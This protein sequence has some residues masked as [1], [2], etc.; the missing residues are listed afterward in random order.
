MARGQ[1]EDV[2]ACLH[3]LLRALVTVFSQAE[4]AEVQH[5]IGVGE[6]GLALDTVVDIILEEDKPVTAEALLAIERAAEL[7]GLSNMPLE[8]L[9]KHVKDDAPP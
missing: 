1:P 4:T 8:E 7:M 2:I 9:R 6:Y 3:A 5:F